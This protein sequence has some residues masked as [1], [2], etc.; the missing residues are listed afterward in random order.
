M[1]IHVKKYILTLQMFSKII[2][3][4]EIGRFKSID[5][6]HSIFTMRDDMYISTDE[7]S[8][9]LQSN[10]SPR[11]SRKPSYSLNIF[12]TSNTYS[13][14]NTISKVNDKQCT[15][16]VKDIQRGD[17]I[18]IMEYENIDIDEYNMHMFM[19]KYN[20][21]LKDMQHKSDQPSSKS[22]IFDDKEIVH[23][24]DILPDIPLS[25]HETR[26]TMHFIDDDEISII[27]H[28]P[29][30]ID[31]I[32]VDKKTDELSIPS[33]TEYKTNTFGMDI[34]H[35]FD[36]HNMRGA[37]HSMIALQ[38]I[39]NSCEVAHISNYGA[40]CSFIRDFAAEKI[41]KNMIYRR[42]QKDENK[43]DESLSEMKN[44]DGNLREA[45][46]R[47]PPVSY[48]CLIYRLRFVLIF[49]FIFVLFFLF[50]F[51]GILNI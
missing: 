35:I 23:L 11:D 29:Q 9:R 32:I 27:L 8:Y 1:M 2:Y 25:S 40:V 50:I 15:V 48:R 22:I 51:F 21:Q 42:M 24:D 12:D 5:N 19:H 37:I 45:L 41:A 14:Y 44:D 31:H 17:I 36:V 30:I 4:I 6:S 33:P 13:L 18:F 28:H 47:G 16:H 10:V 34:D 3:F 38:S 26:D 43:E 46:G 39:G 49:L 20:V 7:I